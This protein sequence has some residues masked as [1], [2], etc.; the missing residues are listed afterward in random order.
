MRQGSKRLFRDLNSV[1]GRDSPFNAIGQGLAAKR[2]RNDEL[3]VYETGILDRQNI[4]MIQFHRNLDLAKKIFVACMQVRLWNLQRNAGPVNRV[5]CRVD[6][7]E[8][9]R[10]DAAEDAIFTKLLPGS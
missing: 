8:R 4:G 6:V 10:R 1:L 5:R 7:G 2:H 3:I 9:P